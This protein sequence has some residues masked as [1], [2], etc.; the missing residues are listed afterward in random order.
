MATSIVD[1]GLRSLSTFGLFA[2]V[3][4]LVARILPSP[5]PFTAEVLL[6]QTVSAVVNAEKKISGPSVEI[7]S[8]ANAVTSMWLFTVSV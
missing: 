4:H 7:P 8:Q 1:A 3:D 2:N 5:A 6:R